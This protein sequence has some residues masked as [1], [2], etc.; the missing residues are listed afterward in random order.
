MS[1][2]SVKE[3]GIRVLDAMELDLV[4]GGS[5][6]VEDNPGWGG[7]YDDAAEY[8]HN[9]YDG[10]AMQGF[11]EGAVPV[12]VGGAA[13]YL[14]S[15]VPV[16]GRRVAGVVAAGVGGLAAKKVCPAVAQAGQW[17]VNAI[18]GHHHHHHHHHH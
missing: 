12:I 13:N 5:A 4:G 14:G 10:D 16:I 3:S 8:M 15:R 11:C 9:F 7:W 6:G 18:S 1:R 17:A 2:G